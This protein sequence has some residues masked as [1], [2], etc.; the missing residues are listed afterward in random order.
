MLLTS[1]ALG[2]AATAPRRCP[3]CGA[4]ACACTP[5]GA[6]STHRPVDVPVRH[7]LLGGGDTMAELNVYVD[8]QG[9]TWKLTAE[10]AREFGYKPYAKPVA[11]TTPAPTEEA[12]ST[13]KPPA[14]KSR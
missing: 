8:P 12:K 2:A 11:A 7:T 9:N 13:P 14:D 10:Q 5:T 6:P 3:V 1:A 4:A